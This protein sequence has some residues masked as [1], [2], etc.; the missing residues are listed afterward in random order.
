M[1]TLDDV[2][3]RIGLTHSSVYYSG[4]DVIPTNGTRWWYVII[5]SDLYSFVA[6]GLC[7]YYLKLWLIEKVY[8]IELLW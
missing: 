4:C 1:E 5:Y 2:H 6:N 3:L 8:S 7:N